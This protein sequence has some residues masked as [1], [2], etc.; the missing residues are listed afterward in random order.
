MYIKSFT[1]LRTSKILT[2]QLL[3]A[4]GNGLVTSPGGELVLLQLLHLQGGAL[5]VHL[6]DPDE[7][8]DGQHTNESEIK[9]L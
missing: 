1:S 3:P 9:F 7:V 5:V 8:R 4:S 6:E 2:R